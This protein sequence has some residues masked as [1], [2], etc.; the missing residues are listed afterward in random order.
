M[1]FAHVMGIPIEE[2]A[3]SLAPAGPAILTGAALVARAKLA[4]IV[5]WLRRHST[6]RPTSRD[7]RVG[8]S[9]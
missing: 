6:Q 4:E 1:T 8:S 5:G 9:S 7:R 2:S 3:L